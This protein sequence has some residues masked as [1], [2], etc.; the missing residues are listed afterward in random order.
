LSAG[1][2]CSAGLGDPLHFN[3]L[4]HFFGRALKISSFLCILFS[5][6]LL[7][8][9]SSPVPAQG[10]ELWLRADSGVRQSGQAVTAWTDQSGKGHDASQATSANSPL[11]VA[12][13]VQGKPVVRFNGSNQFLRFNLPVNGLSQMTIV[14]VSSSAADKDGSWNGTDSS[15]ITWDETGDWG[16][17]DLNPLRRYVKFRFGTGQANNLPVYTRASPLKGEFSLST[18]IKNGSAESLF[19]DGKSAFT[20]SGRLAKIY[21]A[22]AAANLGRGYT[23][24]FAGDIAEVLVY[25]RALST[26]ER[27][28]VENYLL[29]KYIKV[30][31]APA[32]RAPTVSAGSGQTITLP[33]SATLAAKIGDD[34]L[35]SNKLAVNWSVVSG[36]GTVRFSNAASA[37]SSAAFSAP[38]S[39]TLKVTA[40]DGDLSASDDLTVKVAAAQVFAPEE[41]MLDTPA[42][43]APV[44]GAKTYATPDYIY[45]RDSGYFN[46][47][48]EPYNCY[49]D[50][51]H[52]DTACIKAAMDAAMRVGPTGGRHATVYF[53]EGTYLISDSLLWATYGN[54]NAVVTAKVD[55]SRGCITGFTIANAG[56][57][58]SPA[59]WS[60][61]G[62]SN[63]GPAL[64]L[65]GGGGSGA[66]FYT[67]RGGDGWV[68]GIQTGLG[69]LG[70]ANCAGRGYTS[71][72]TVKVLNWRAYLRFEG[73][74]KA[75][76]IIKLTDNNPKFQNANCTLSPHGD[77]QASEY[78]NAVIMTASERDGN[79]IGSGENAYE[80]DIWNMTISTGSGNPG[81]IA[82]DWVGSNRAS[83]KN[84]N[85]VSGDGKGRS[86]LNVSR[87]STG[88]TGP[89]YVKNVSIRGFDYGIYANSS[90][91]EV[92][93][94]FEYID[95]SNIHTAGVVNGNMPNWFRQVFSNISVPAFI[96]QG[97][98]SLLV[99]DGNFTGGS[100]NTTAIRAPATSAGGVM[101]VRNIKTS[102]YSAALAVGS[103]NTAVA[104]ANI[105]E[106]AYPEPAAQFPSAMASLNLSNIPNT[107]EY[108]DNNLSNWASVSSYGAACTPNSGKD[109]TSCIQAAMNSGKPVVYFPFGGYWA[110]STI[111][112]PSSV[113]AVLGMNSV[114]QSATGTGA[115]P[116]G[117]GKHRAAYC[118]IQFDGSGSHPVEFRNFGFQQSTQSNT[119]C[120]NGSAP[121]VLADTSGGVQISNTAGGS[122][123]IYLENVAVPNANYHLGQNQHVYARQYDVE[124]GTGVHVTSNGG[125]WWMFGFK[126]EGAGLLWNVSNATF[127]LLGSFGTTAHGPSSSP[128]FI[129]KNSNFS[130][131]GVATKANGWGISVSETKN[132]TTLNTPVNR[133]WLG[134][135][136]YGLYSGHN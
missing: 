60:L 66:E 84:V 49:G 54:N 63:P 19:V 50:G 76:T 89:D 95:L 123:T 29:N 115:Y 103:G 24:Y 22:S 126:S 41:A 81:A 133:K 86:G 1:Q 43:S 130:L 72:P 51:R 122:G 134:G 13:V 57:G 56:S 44:N 79:S 112:V 109:A 74:N 23:G 39:Y 53:P 58:Y 62:E 2:G 34:G 12:N 52:D 102:G 71:A 3:K 80:N 27:E 18:A 28:S 104:G 119:F 10:L 17:V 15:P 121:L 64:Y 110:S 125:I 108:I 77:N 111:H 75:K 92:G 96:N 105:S 117:D 46:V 55:P 35:P 48:N 124:S 31:A 25:T 61:H 120:Y 4:L 128:A 131:A 7:A 90:A 82:L 100:S 5:A 30:S 16:T 136:G 42:E 6:C 127:E 107:P 36:P 113:R 116:N 67:T 59:S 99:T 87:G 8:D 33:A 45:P 101:F 93:N 69:N 114:L 65:F 132:G 129:F 78:C 26:A 118:T 21:R 88:G 47:K 94:T 97:S 106:Y 98:G 40:S 9:S 70:S 83:V 20:Q 37:S 14:L 73:Q 85:L 68:T 38:G 135:I 91:H 32:N 11:L